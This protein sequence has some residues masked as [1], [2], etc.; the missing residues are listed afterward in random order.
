MTVGQRF[1]LLAIPATILFS[2]FSAPAS[3]GQ[4]VGS[5]DG[6]WNGTIG[7]R[8]P[9]PISISIT[10][11]QVVSFT[12]NGASF[13]VQFTKATPTSVFFADKTHYTMTL[14][15]T[16]NTTASAKLHGGRVAV[17]VAGSLTEGIDEV[18]RRPRGE[19]RPQV[20][21]SPVQ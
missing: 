11:G 4:D 18:M 21:V 17:T 20:Y 15:K 7:K 6:T 3:W 12:E 14:I 2:L 13:N 1:L 5:W 10:H 19:I 9:W 8:H 16:G